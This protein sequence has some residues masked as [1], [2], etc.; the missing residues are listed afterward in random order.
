MS[1]LPMLSTAAIVAQ[2]QAMSPVADPTPGL[3]VRNLDL[4]VSSLNEEA[5]LSERGVAACNG[6]LAL[7]ERKRIEVSHWCATEPEIVRQPVDRPVFLTGLPRSGTTYFQY[8]FD[9]EPSFRMMRTWEGESPCPPPAVDSASAAR[10]Q[11]QCAEQHRQRR[12]NDGGAHDSFHLS[13]PDGPQECVMIMDQTF[14]NA[15]HYWTFRVPSYFDRVLD[16]I[17]LTACYAHHKRVLKTLQWQAP[18]SRWALKWPCHL[19]ALDEI[20]QVFPDAA[21]VV[22]HRDPVAVLASNCSYATF[23]RGMFSDEV[24]RAELGRQMKDLV[25]RHIRA[26]VDFDANRADGVTIAHVDY[27]QVVADPEAA[28]VDVY[29]S[30]DLELTPAVRQSIANWRAE[31]PP[32]KRGIHRYDLS[33]YGLNID[34][35]AEEFAFYTERFDLADKLRA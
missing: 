4:L 17:D 1:G 19:L 5:R 35:V 18:P 28:M 23:L 25:S 11:A 7:A 6:M 30:L 2:A 12:Q 16:T 34:E 24:D 10:R 26:L 22:T 9:R 13:D 3:F 21:M 14:G 8:L 20:R 27:Q 15:G 32:G 31:N 29:R 33:D